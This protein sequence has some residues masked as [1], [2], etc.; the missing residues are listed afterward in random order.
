MPKKIL[1]FFKW[2]RLGRLLL[3]TVV[4]LA[5]ITGITKYY[6]HYVDDIGAVILGDGLLLAYIVFCPLYILV[7][8]LFNPK[9]IITFILK[10]IAA[11]IVG[12]PCLIAIIILYFHVI[13]KFSHTDI[14]YS[15][16]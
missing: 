6:W 10:Y 2:L 12:T 3:F 5:V 8:R 15:V 16:R 1:S 11:V 13:Q 7:D 14:I 4:W 9:N